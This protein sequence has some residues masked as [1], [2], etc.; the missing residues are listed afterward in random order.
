MGRAHSLMPMTPRALAALAA[1][2]VLCA[3]ARASTGAAALQLLGQAQE[4]YR[5][6]EF[7]DALRA[8][9]EALS[10]DSRSGAAYELRARLWHVLGDPAKQRKDAERA[11]SL[12]GGGR[13]DA[14]ALTAQ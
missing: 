8:V 5:R 10:N 7:R 14:E 6:G 2:L 3:P 4:K 13:L 1:A 9:E 12:I 11:L